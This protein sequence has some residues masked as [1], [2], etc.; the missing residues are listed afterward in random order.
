MKIKL[1]TVYLVVF[2]LG[3]LTAGILTG[4]YGNDIGVLVS[5]G[6]L[7]A[8]G[9]MIL[10]NAVM[11]ERISTLKVEPSEKKKEPT[12]QE[13]KDLPDTLGKD[14][15]STPEEVS[16]KIEPLKEP[17]E[18]KEE[19]PKEEPKKIQLSKEEAERFDKI[20]LYIKGNLEKGHDLKKITEVLQKVYTA[21][22]IN[23]VLDNAFKVKEP[24]LPD[25][26]EPE[27]VKEEITDETKENKEQHEATANLKDPDKKKFKEKSEEFKCEKCGQ[28][29]RTAGILRNHIRLSKK[30]K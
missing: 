1:S 24:E 15:E 2:V 23:F 19:T 26:G 10:V 13:I 25:L 11:I 3:V 30:C 7:G 28:V 8:Y 12:A 9:I 6:F 14:E 20:A 27:E 18:I 29:L 4:I 17:E 22:M 16:D 21:E 5:Y